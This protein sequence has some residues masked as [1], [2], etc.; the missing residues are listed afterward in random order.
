MAYLI[1]DKESKQ[2]V[3]NTETDPTLG[4]T[5]ELGAAFKVYQGTIDSEANYQSAYRPNAADNGLESPYEGLP[6]AEQVVKF[7]EEQTI[8]EAQN[9]KFI[10]LN[11]IKTECAKQ[12]EGEFGSDTWKLDKAREKDLLSGSNSAMTA[13]AQEKQSIRDANNAHE[14]TLKALDPNVLADAKKIIEFDATKFGLNANGD[15]GSGIATA[16]NR[17]VAPS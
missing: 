17:P 6:K 1:Y 10:K 14:A 3:G 12:I 9:T 11:Q 13:I 5:I 4:G 15:W 2:C 16:P 8:L 7:G